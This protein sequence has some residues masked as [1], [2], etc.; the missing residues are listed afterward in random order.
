MSMTELLTVVTFFALALAVLV[1]QRRASG[2][3]KHRPVIGWLAYTVA[4]GCFVSGVVLL[5][6]GLN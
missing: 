6:L 1:K 2:C 5:Y 4:A 3:E